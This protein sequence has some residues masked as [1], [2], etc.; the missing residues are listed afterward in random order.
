[1][2]VKL[3]VLNCYAPGQSGS[4]DNV[5]LVWLDDLV[6]TEPASVLDRIDLI[7]DHVRLSL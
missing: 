7:P 4:Q 2:R 3:E 1:M 5:T 6:S